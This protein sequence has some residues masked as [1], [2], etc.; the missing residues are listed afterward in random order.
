MCDDE[1][2]QPRDYVIWRL[3]YAQYEDDGAKICFCRALVSCITTEC[4]IYMAQSAGH[5]SQQAIY[6]RLIL[7][8]GRIPEFR[9]KKEHIT[10]VSSWNCSFNIY[11][12]VRLTTLSVA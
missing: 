7:V 9:I 10:G 3:K 12:F 4:S 8:T 5:P 2:W 1:T 11:L 6:H